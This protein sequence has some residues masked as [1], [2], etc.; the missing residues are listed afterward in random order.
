M[1][2]ILFTLD[3]EIHGNGEGC[4]YEL[5]VKPVDRMLAQFDQ[6]GAKLTIMADIA[7]ILKFKEYAESSGTDAWHYHRIVQHLQTAVR[8]GHDVQLHIH[9]SYFNARQDG[10][11]WEQDWSEY[12]FAG[13]G[14]DRMKSVIRQG[15]EFLE[16]ILQTANPDYRCIAFRAANWSVSPSQNVVRAL[17]ENGIKIDSSVFKYGHREGLVSF[18]YSSAESEIGP[19]RAAQDGIWRRDP[20]GKIWE[21]PIYSEKRWIGGFLSVSRIYRVLLGR[22]HRIPRDFPSSQTKN[23]PDLPA[24]RSI[25]RRLGLFAR[26]HAWKAD[27]NQCTGRQLI[28]ALKRAEERHGKSG[29]ERTFVLI[30]HSKLFNRI[31]ERSLRPFL[32]YVSARHDRFA[33]G[34][35]DSLNLENSVFSSETQVNCLSA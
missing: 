14:F 15:K 6:Y 18:D 24:R 31:N 25:S 16:S 26:K 22:L 33:F 9:S 21:V 28:R 23:G 3:Y 29:S 12:N 32:A 8:R 1:L 7:E 19:W 35:F 34:K 20:R 17:L 4:P 30:G 27:F 2:K 11:R 5:M 13:L 10:R